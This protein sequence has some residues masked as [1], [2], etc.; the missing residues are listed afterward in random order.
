VSWLS[1]Q[2]LLRT[3]IW[4]GGLPERARRGQRRR[5]WGRLLCAR[6]ETG[7]SPS[8]APWRW[9][10]AGLQ[11]QRSR[12]RGSAWRWRGWPTASH[13]PAAGLAVSGAVSHP[14]RVHSWARLPSEKTPLEM[15]CGCDWSLHHSYHAENQW[16]QPRERVEA[17]ST[18]WSCAA[19]QSHARCRE[20]PPRR[21]LDRQ[22]SQPQRPRTTPAGDTSRRRRGRGG[23]SRPTPAPT[24]TPA[25]AQHIP[26]AL[27]PTLGALASTKETPG[28]ASKD[29]HL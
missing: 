26:C 19:R 17:V 1:V 2:P 22:Q 4:L 29:Q 16:Q 12:W 20:T 15:P 18:A 27:L 7:A 11:S 3:S 8:F 13:P 21:P 28:P 24:A 5:V 10:D 6:A 23:T 14:R 25:P 9:P